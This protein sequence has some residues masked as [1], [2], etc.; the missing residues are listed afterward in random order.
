MVYGFFWL[1][2]PLRGQVLPCARLWCPVPQDVEGCHGCRDV[3]APA[4]PLG[5]PQ[6]SLS[7]PVLGWPHGHAVPCIENN[8]SRWLKSRVTLS[9]SESSTP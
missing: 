8:C 6:P 3:H 9:C 7:A 4:G 2:E 1:P 5:T